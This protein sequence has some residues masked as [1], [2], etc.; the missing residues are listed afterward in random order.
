MRL[1]TVEFPGYQ[2]YMQCVSEDAIQKRFMNVY[3]Y[4]AAITQ[5]FLGD[6]TPGF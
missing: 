5:I 1:L 3:L 2:S 6:H 4:A